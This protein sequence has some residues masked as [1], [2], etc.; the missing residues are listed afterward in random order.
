METCPT[1]GIRKA[2]NGRR[3]HYYR[4]HRQV[5]CCLWVL[6]IIAP[7]GHAAPPLPPLLDLFQDVRI[8]N[9][10]VT[11]DGTV[12]AFAKSGRLLRRGEDGGRTWSEQL[13][14]KI[15]LAR[16]TLDWLTQ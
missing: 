3:A 5:A 10:V 7:S 11:T 2:T 1:T 9:I 16:V 6:L 15:S 14:E 13:Y 8:P 4:M 12:L